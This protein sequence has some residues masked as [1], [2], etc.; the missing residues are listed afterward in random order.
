M[1]FDFRDFDGEWTKVTQEDYEKFVSYLNQ[2]HEDERPLYGVIGQMT[3]TAFKFIHQIEPYA[4]ALFFKDHLVLSIHNYTTLTLRAR[5]EWPLSDIAGIRVHKNPATSIVEFQLRDG[6]KVK[7][8]RVAHKAA[9]PLDRFTTEGSAAFDGCL[10]DWEVYTPYF[11][12]CNL[13]LPLPEEP[14]KN[15]KKGRS[16]F[17][18]HCGQAVLPAAVVCKHCKQPLKVG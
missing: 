7:F 9:E 10:Q 1:P 3:S 2:L 6:S 13:G 15:E 16:A 8:K 11:L 12:A 17:C 18:P 14:F 5:Q 4:T